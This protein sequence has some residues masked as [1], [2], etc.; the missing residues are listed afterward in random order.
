MMVEFLAGIQ[1]ITTNLSMSFE[2][3]VLVVVL[4]GCLMFY[5]K[6]FRLGLLLSFFVSA[7]CFAWFYALEVNYVPALVF[8]ILFAAFLS[9][10]LAVSKSSGVSIT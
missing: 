3:I 10:N 4:I 2:T 8:T 9:L 1:T 7:L 5:A 6:D